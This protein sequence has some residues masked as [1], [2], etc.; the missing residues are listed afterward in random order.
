MKFLIF[1]VAIF[2]LP[3]LCLF[4][5]F[6]T[7]LLCGRFLDW[8]PGMR[9]CSLMKRFIFRLPPPRISAEQAKE[10]VIQYYAVTRGRNSEFS[11]FLRRN[12]RA[13]ERACS[14]CVVTPRIIDVV[15]HVD[16]QSGQVRIVWDGNNIGPSYS[17]MQLEWIRKNCGEQEQ[18]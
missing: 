2:L 5:L 9:R 1:L 16:N 3:I 13:Y 11:D 10:I 18:K 17:Q 4:L 8:E 14:W 6:C 7:L 15:F 12:M